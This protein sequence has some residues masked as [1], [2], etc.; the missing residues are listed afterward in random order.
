MLLRAY[1]GNETEVKQDLVCRGDAELSGGH[2]E[3]KAS[4]PSEDGL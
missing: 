3:G 4:G 2:K 1:G